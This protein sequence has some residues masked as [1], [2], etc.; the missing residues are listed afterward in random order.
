MHFNRFKI[1]YNTVRTYSYIR[2]QL[3]IG[4]GE[5]RNRAIM[6]SLSVRSIAVTMSMFDNNILYYASK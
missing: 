2:V 5:S 6:R 3:N 4:T 1:V